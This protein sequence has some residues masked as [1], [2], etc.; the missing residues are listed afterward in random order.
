MK[1]KKKDLVKVERVKLKDHFG[2]KPGVWLTLMYTL[3][4]L[5]LIFFI[6]ILPGLKNGQKRVTFESEAGNVSVYSDGIY[7]GGTPFTTWVKSGNHE[8]SFQAYS[9]EIDRMDIQVS[10]PIFFSWL[11][12]RHQKVISNQTLDENDLTKVENLFLQSLSE[13]SLVIE[14]DETHFY[15]PLF[16]DFAK[17]VKNTNINNDFNFWN[18]AFSFISSQTMLEDAKETAKLL[19]LD[20][21]FSLQ[22]K[23]FTNP[24]YSVKTTF[25]VTDKL[26]NYEQLENIFPS[27]TIKGFSVNKGS[28]LLGINDSLTYPEVITGCRNVSVDE[29]NISSKEVSEYQWALFMQANP[30][31]KKS[32]IDML[33]SEGLV[34]EYYLA[35][36]SPSLIIPSNKPIVNISFLAAKAFCEWLSGESKNTYFVPNENQ[37]EVAGLQEGADFFQKYLISTQN[38]NTL[39]SYLGGVWEFT[40]TPFIPLARV[41]IQK[42]ININSLFDNYQINSNIIIKGGSY[43]SDPSNINKSTVGTMAQNECSAYTGFRVAWI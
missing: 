7:L 18:L 6:G 43:I 5:V 41:M 2:M 30:K 8:I 9:I 42:N 28:Y 21:D 3:I 37:W 27:F 32:N 4:L 20:Y 13:Q 33:I 10:H 31:W 17:L 38:D 29:F 34:D 16:T 25:A 22:E 19:S 24:D 14:Y 1:F 12:K 35:G 11:F 26:Q 15:P 36:I 39:Q 40:T 23:I